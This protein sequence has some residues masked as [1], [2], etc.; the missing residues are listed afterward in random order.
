M[1]KQQ[2][3]YIIYLVCAIFF[4]LGFDF[5][6]VFFKF[7]PRAFQP[8]SMPRKPI[9]LTQTPPQTWVKVTLVGRLGNQLFIA[10]SGNGIAKRRNAHFCIENLDG[11]LLSSAVQWDSSVLQN[12]DSNANYT[13]L[14][15]D[16]YFGTY[17]SKF[18]EF[19]LNESVHLKVYLQSYK[20]FQGIPFSLKNTEWARMW[21]LANKIVLGIHIRRTDFMQTEQYIEISPTLRYYEAALGI[22]N[23][24]ASKDSIFV[25]SDDLEWV[26][27]QDLF[28]GMTLSPFTT[29]LEDLGVLSQ[30][31]HLIIGAGTFGWWSLQLNPH[32]LKMYYR[33]EFT[34]FFRRNAV[35]LEDYYVPTWR[36][37]TD[38]DIQSYFHEEA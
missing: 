36:G 32:G 7:K 1:R 8:F 18:I 28:R 37:I 27:Q 14:D 21:V 34:K 29:S 35:N 24:N 2:C 15:E 3:K 10:A 4:K 6:Y 12:C 23:I 22:L 30:C 19:N 17:L 9:E 13:E 5:V 38:K 11:S 20:Y 16:G 31:F 33:K 26:R 25:A